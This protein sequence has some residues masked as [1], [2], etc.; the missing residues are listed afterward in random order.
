MKGEMI[1]KVTTYLILVIITIAMVFCEFGKSSQVEVISQNLQFSQDSN[2]DINA[3]SISEPFIKASIK[4]QIQNK[5]EKAVKNI[6]ITYK[7]PRGI[8]TAKI[9]ALKPG[10]KADFTTNTYKSKNKTYY[11]S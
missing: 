2:F 7:F 5:G 1:M 4:G 9:S 11:I 8:V 10:Q 6:I 3:P